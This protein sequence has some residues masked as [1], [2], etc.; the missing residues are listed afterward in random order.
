MRVQV[1]VRVVVGAC[2]GLPARA[3]V[4]MRVY[5]SG[6]YMRVCACT[7][8]YACMCTMHACKYLYGLACACSRAFSPLCMHVF[9]R[10]FACMRVRTNAC[11]A[12]ECSF[13][14]EFFTEHARIVLARMG[15][16]AR[17]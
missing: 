13:P 12:S 7:R 15:D 3:Y 8:L 11:R 16:Y 14:A 17:V 10:V 5:G 2:M 1:L 4:R 9:T 6:V